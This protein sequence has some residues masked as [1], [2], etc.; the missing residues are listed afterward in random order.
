[1]KDLEKVQQIIANVKNVEDF[2]LSFP[3]RSELEISFKSIIAKRMKHCYDALTTKE[4][5]SRSGSGL[6]IMFTDGT[7]FSY[8]VYEALDKAL[9]QPMCK[10]DKLIWQQIVRQL[11]LSKDDKLF[12]IATEYLFIL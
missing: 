1:M 11:Y 7:H 3:N 12:N 9:K 10:W 8:P 6:I 4:I 2:C 5:K